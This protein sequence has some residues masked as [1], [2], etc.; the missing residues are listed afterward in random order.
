MLA[1]QLGRPLGIDDMYID[2]EL[3]LPFD[4]EDFPVL[5]EQT[6]RLYGHPAYAHARLHWARSLVSDEAIVEASLKPGMHF[7]VES[8]ALTG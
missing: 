6:R 4:D 7:I 1:V 2:A 3:P 5:W 8:S